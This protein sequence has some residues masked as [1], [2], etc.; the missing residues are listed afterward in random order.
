M[1]F[2]NEHFLSII[3]TI[4]GILTAVWLN[5]F[6]QRLN[7][8]TAGAVAISALCVAAGLG[9]VKAFAF[10][11]DL[12]RDYSGGMSLFG[13]VFCM[14]AVF[15]LI[16]RLT[17]QPSG[18]VFDILT[19]P[20]VLTLML[21]RLNCL[22]AGCCYGI[23]INGTSMRYPT[24]ETELLFYAILL[25]ILAPKVLKGRSYGEVYPLFMMSYGIFRAVNECF[26]YSASAAGILH[27]AHIWAALSAVLGASIYMELKNRRSK[28]PYVKH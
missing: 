3:L 16:V 2:I 1:V 14:P 9:S 11:E 17:K 18:E 4:A 10:M 7:I 28:R 8:G 24:R 12:G 13:A 15:Y 25:V 23:I 19:I 22:H 20:F 6:R 21:A 27:V 5:L 26:R